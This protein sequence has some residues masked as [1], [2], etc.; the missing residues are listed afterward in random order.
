MVPPERP[1]AMDEPTTDGAIAAATYVLDVYT[2]TVNTGDVD[3]WQSVTL[4]S[5]S[6]CA[7]VSA[8]VE[9]RNAEGQ[10]IVGGDAVVGESRATEISAGQWFSVE[11]SVLQRAS[12][13]VDKDGAELSARADKQHDMV[14]ALSWD[15]GFRVDEMGVET[16]TS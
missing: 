6:F 16:E 10:R 14:F 2:Y 5:C 7:G 9:A 12:S 1:A 13:R 4:P 3:L 15:D 8:D 11:M